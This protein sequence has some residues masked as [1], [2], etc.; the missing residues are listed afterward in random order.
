MSEGVFEFEY[1]PTRQ[2]IG[3]GKGLMSKSFYKGGWRWALFCL[4]LLNGASYVIMGALVSFLLL[5]AWGETLQSQT[6]LYYLGFVGIP[7]GALFFARIVHGHMRQVY[8]HR[9]LPKQFRV[10]LSSDGV[11]FRSAH[12]SNRTGWADVDDI[13]RGKGMTVL[14]TGA[15]GLILPDRLLA[16]AGDVAEIN[17]AISQWFDAARGSRA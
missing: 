8:V 3:A 14:V 17:R 1:Q 10:H 9:T 13:V 6:F 2:E 5:Q 11:D 15:C 4:G 12:S 7:I 16:E